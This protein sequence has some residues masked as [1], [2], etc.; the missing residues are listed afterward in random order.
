MPTIYKSA[1]LPRY[2]NDI[3]KATPKSVDQVTIEPNGTWSQNTKPASPKRPN[4]AAHGDSDDDD[5]VEIKDTRVA[6]FKNEAISTPSAFART[7]PL[8]HREP[9]ATSATSR[10]STGKRPIEQVIDLTFSDNDDE[11]PTRAPKRQTVQNSLNS[12]PESRSGTV[13]AN[14]RGQTNGVTVGTTRLPLLSTSNPGWSGY[15]NNT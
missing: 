15:R 1:N 7:P 14:D 9:S 13:P 6:S 8:S 5:L 11:E 4:G 3:L 2:V 12:V 10:A